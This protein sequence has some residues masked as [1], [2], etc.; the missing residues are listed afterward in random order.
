MESERLRNSLLS[1]I[2]HDLRTPLTAIVGFA[3]MLA[4]PG[5]GEGAAH[6]AP[7]ELAE[8]IYD[9]ALR[10]TGIVTNLLDMVR[11][12]EGSMR[13]NRQ[14]S[15]LEELIGA[16]LRASRRLLS[17]RNIETHVPPDLPLVRLDAVLVERL[18]ANLLDNAAKYTPAASPVT[19]NAAAVE[20]NNHRYVRVNVEDSG[21]GLAPGMESRVFDKFTRGEKESALPGIGLGLAICR[22]I[23][24]AHGGKIGA[25]NRVDTNGKVL[26]ACFWFMLPADETPPAETESADVVS[27]DK[28]QDRSQNAPGDALSGTQAS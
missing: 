19:I 12:Q 13:L 20:E 2:S 9:E 6:R 16:A 14:W 5:R 11:L 27:P 28:S 21:P 25:T 1:A 15:S 7:N 23:V 22:A 17:G 3:S 18:L 8:A 26:G 4:E 24:E 10:M